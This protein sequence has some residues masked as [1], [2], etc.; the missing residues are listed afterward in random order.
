MVSR[1]LACVLGGALVTAI[2]QPLS[3]QPFSDSSGPAWA[4]AALAKLAAKGFIQ[5]YPDGRRGNRAMTRDEMA[6][7]VARVLANVETIE[8]QWPAPQRPQAGPQPGSPP[9]AQQ[10]QVTRADIDLLRRLVADLKDELADLGVRVPAVEQ[11]L[12]AIEPRLDN[13]KVTGTTRF[14]EN[15]GRGA[16]GAGSP[17]GVNGNPLTTSQSADS[18]PFT[19]SAQFE[20]KLNV[21]GAVS[22]EL[23]MIAAVMTQGDSFN[24]FNSGNIATA[25]KAPAFGSQPAT[26]AFGNGAFGSLDSAF[27]DW[28]RQ[29]GS[30][31]TPSKLEAWLGRFGANP[32]PNCMADC[33]PVQ[34]GPFGLLMNDTGATWTDSTADSGV[35]AADGLRVALHL[36][37]ALDLQAQALLVRVQGATGG[38]A[39]EAGLP[40]PSDA[41]IFGEDAYGFDANIQI[42]IWSRL[43]FYYVGNQIRQR[44]TPPGLGASAAPGSGTC[45]DRAAVR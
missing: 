32:Q 14:L 34:F 4:F 13:A 29:W 22:D 25:T 20:F 9:P 11:E 30:T 27:L 26:A 39:T 1:M 19:N 41:Y 38:R 8:H 2:I 36:P 12:A 15:V 3:A 31:D 6:V 40:V 16:V 18:A 43:G 21:D 17:T 37:G 24:V 44:K 7:V 45:T 35:N 23:H 33:Y 28:T 42:N 10:P 5:G